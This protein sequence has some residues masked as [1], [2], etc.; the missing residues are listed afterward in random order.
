M[1]RHGVADAYDRLKAF[2]RGRRVGAAQLREFVATL[3][4]PPE[5]ATRL[6]AMTPS[7]YVGLAAQLARDV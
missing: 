6:A 7:V 5:E 4:L 3:P 2:T 1:R